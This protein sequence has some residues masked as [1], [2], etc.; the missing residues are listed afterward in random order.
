LDALVRSVLDEFESRTDIRHKLEYTVS[1]GSHEV[2]LDR[3]LI[4][5]I[6]NNL[7]SNAIKYSPE[8]KV[9]RINLEYTAS[10]VILKISDEGI[11]IPEADL[12]HLFEPFHRATNVGTISGTGLGLVITREAVELHSGTIGVESQQGV[13]T[14]FIIR[15]PISIGG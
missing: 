5:Q 13:G 4:R 2:E 3:K 12:R 15:I 1:E 7:V 10:E 11:G 8:G 6:I 9:I 14:T